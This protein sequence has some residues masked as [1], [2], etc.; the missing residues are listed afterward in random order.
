MFVYIMVQFK[1]WLLGLCPH[2]GG[3]LDHDTHGYEQKWSH[4]WRCGYCTLAKHANQ[5]RCGV[6]DDGAV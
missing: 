4:C 6:R 2:C 1:R 5:I 3:E